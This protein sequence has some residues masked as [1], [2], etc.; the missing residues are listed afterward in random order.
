M[1]FGRFA[2]ITAL[3]MLPSIGLAC[4]CFTNGKPDNTRTKT[5]CR[6]QD[7]VFIKPGQCQASSISEYL[8]EFR[9]CCGGHSDCDFPSEE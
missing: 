1:H 5:C 8:K 9:D 7:G 6:N 3:A 2:I 4:Q